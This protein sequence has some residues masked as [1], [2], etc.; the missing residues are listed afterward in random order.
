LGTQ[1]SANNALKDFDHLEWTWVEDATTL[2]GISTAAL[3]EQFRIWDV[4]EVAQQQEDYDPEV[5]TRF[6]Y[7]IKI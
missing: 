3:R 1:S 5:I 2:D 4:D 6:R 7:S